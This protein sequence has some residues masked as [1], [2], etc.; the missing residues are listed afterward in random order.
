MKQYF[1]ENPEILTR[2]REI[3]IEI[4]GHRLSFFTNNGLFS[5]DK[6]D[7]GSLTLV[8]N[9]PPLSGSLLDL[10]CGYGF[11]GIALA[12]KNAAALT[13]SDINA[14]ALSYAE[15]NAKLNGVKAEFIHSDGFGQISAKFDNITLNPPIHAG[16]AVMY[17]LFEESA[18][19]LTPGGSFF[20]VIQKKHGAETSIKKLRGIFPHVE[21]LHKKKGTFVLQC[22]V[23]IP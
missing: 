17:R 18:A 15:K 14:L 1:I 19:N 8:E 11:I 4:F 20:I 2:E 13:L 12:K 21:I 23:D 6:I 22:T 7:E 5:C 16:K 3:S 9:L 10:G